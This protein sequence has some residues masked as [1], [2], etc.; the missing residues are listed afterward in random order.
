MVFTAVSDFTS[1]CKHPCHLKH[2]EKRVENTYIIHIYG[3]IYIYVRVC[4]YIYYICIYM[5]EMC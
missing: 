4:V 2:V 3:I 5:N 1:C